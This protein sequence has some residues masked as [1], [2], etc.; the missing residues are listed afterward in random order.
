M[1]FNGETGKKTPNK[2]GL[3]RYYHIVGYDINGKPIRKN[4]TSKKSLAEAK[5]AGVYNSA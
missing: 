5:S 2:Q 3:Y 4:F 1:C